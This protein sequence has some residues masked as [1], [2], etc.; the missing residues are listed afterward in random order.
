MEILSIIKSIIS[1][2]YC[3]KFGL[4]F[5]RELTL[6]NVPDTGIN[7]GKYEVIPAK[8]KTEYK[9]LVRKYILDLFIESQL[10]MTDFIES[11]LP[12]TKNSENL[13]NQTKLMTKLSNIDSKSTLIENN[14][15][16]NIIQL[17]SAFYNLASST[18]PVEQNHA[19][20]YNFVYNSLNNFGLAIKI[21]IDV[22][23]KEVNLK[24]SSYDIAFKI[25]LGIYLAIYITSY[26]IALFLFS[27]VIQRKK[28][29]MR[30]F[31]NIN[32]DF[33]S[34]SITKCEQF[35]NRFKLAEENKRKDDEA[36]DSYDEKDSLI[37]SEKNI[38]IWV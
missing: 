28:S 9:E 1:I 38:R 12:I 7:G 15:I 21:L 4:Y 26:I 33:I 27:K 20:L 19:D 22:Y 30:V 25:Q 35:I 16:I 13:L 11:T 23:M 34:L 8:N 29:Y 10:A 3:N 2:N 18:S 32:Y 36:D 14:V 17:N 24:A 5:I 31:L 37:K 6:L